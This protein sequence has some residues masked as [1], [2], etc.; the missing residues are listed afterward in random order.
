[1]YTFWQKLSNQGILEGQDAGLQGKIRIINQMTL[2]L[3]LMAFSYLA[4]YFLFLQSREP[5]VN[6]SWFLIFYLGLLLLPLP[7]L[8]LNRVQWYL[9]SRYLLLL[10]LTALSVGNSYYV[11]YAYRTEF[12]FFILAT[13]S[14][15]I[16]D[17]W[18]Y[19]AIAF[20]IESVGFIL[21]VYF[22]AQAHPMAG[23]VLGSFVVRSV[24]A[25]FLLFLVLYLIQREA[26][27]Y[28][29]EIEVKNM[30]LSA[31]RDEMVK[32]NFTKDKIFSIISHDL[33]SPIASL[34]AALS[35]L[36]SEHL[37]VDEFKKA[38]IG[39]EKQVEQLHNSLNELLTWSKAQLHGINPEP[40]QFLIKPLIYG[41]VSVTKLAARNKK[42]IVTTNIPPDLE[43]FCDAN[44]LHSVITNLITNAIKFTPVG[45][46]VSIFCSGDSDKIMVHV[47]DTGVGIPSENME[48]I[49]SS[50][51]HF[52]TRGTNNEKGT[53]LGLLMCQE[54]VQK[55]NGTLEVS[56]EDGKGTLFSITLPAKG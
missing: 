18:R 7:V 25:F 8:L 9:L 21:A 30:E 46:A 34:Q 19:Q 23:F 32:M 33:R 12:Y 6:L 52:S 22:I 11:G 37:G 31:E 13:G 15:V 14:F 38:S 51:V 5:I 28:N 50:N 55:N 43:V 35:L 44:M 49:F 4:V 56:S 26:E 47:E 54:F 36:K 48:K 53:G 20:F 39:L 40:T 41:V 2:V 3:A 24:I 42:I 1:M 16:F 10:V 27:K 45:G 17:H 29:E